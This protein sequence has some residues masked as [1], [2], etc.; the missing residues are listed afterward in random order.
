M[1]ATAFEWHNYGKSTIGNRSDIERVPIENLREF[2]RKYYQPDNIVLVIAGKFDEKK[3]IQYIEQY[4]GS[5]KRPSRVLQDTY[6]EEPAQDGERNVVLRRVGKVPVV[7]VVYH[8]PGTAHP[9]FAALDV[10]T[11]ILTAEPSGRLYKALVETKKATSV[12]ASVQA[13]HDPYLLEVFANVA[14]K[15]S[16]E[17]VRDII[18][19][20]MEKLAVGKVSEA[21][22]ARAKRKLLADRDRR[23]TQSDAIALELSE[24]IGAGDWRLLF[25]HRD[26][27]AKVTPADIAEVAAKFFKQ[28]NRTVGMYI[29]T[30]TSDRTPVPE[31]PDLA[32]LVGD[33]KGRPGDRAGREH[34][35]N[36]REPGE[37]HETLHASQR[38]EGRAAA[39]EDAWRN[40]C[41]RHRSAL[42][43]RGIAGG[44]DHPD[45]LSRSAH[46]A[47]HDQ[48]HL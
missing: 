18:T 2:Y 26:R 29:P 37:T 11:S 10:L 16:P 28:S 3:A 40:G 41:R 48:V 33:Y 12:Y 45:Q 9:D 27:I 30:T 47:R 36:P 34:R 15:V 43:Q 24:W 8:V 13:T 14:P 21:E 32:K 38:H 46:D 7:G 20:V 42:W 6:T 31:L 1:T 5:L 23:L 19:E 4:F 35:P 25:I 44:Q 22:V 17:E 39:Q